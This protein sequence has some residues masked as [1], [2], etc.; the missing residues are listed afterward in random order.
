MD[1]RSEPVSQRHESAKMG[2]F[3]KGRCGIKTVLRGT[4]P[5]LAGTRVVV[6]GVRGV[7]V[8]DRNIDEQLNFVFDVRDLFG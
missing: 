2:R 6:F 1:N 4:T 3:S 8:H 5:F 7:R